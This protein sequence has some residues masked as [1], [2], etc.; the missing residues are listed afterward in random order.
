[1]KKSLAVIMVFIVMLFAFVGCVPS[2]GDSINL[3]NVNEYDET[4]FIQSMAADKTDGITLAENGKAS[5]AIVYPAKADG[6]FLMAI[7]DMQRILSEMI[8]DAVVAESDARLQSGY[9]LCIGNTNR[10]DVNLITFA[11]GINNDGYA[12]KFTENKLFL[13]A[14]NN[15]AAINAIYGF[16]EDE[17]GCVWLDMQNDY[18]PSLPTIILDKKDE[19][20]NPSIVWRS[21]YGYEQMNSIAWKNK[22]KLNGVEYADGREAHSGWGTWCHTFFTFLDPKNYYESNPEY[23]SLQ[24]GKRVANQLCLTNENVYDIVRNNL[25]E[26]IAANPDKK[27]WDVSI[28]DVNKGGCECDE[29]SALDKAE[30][31]GMGSL[32]PFINRLADEFPDVMIS[33]LAYFHN[34]EPPKALKP[35][36]N[37]LIKLCAMP[38]DQ[39]SSYALGATKLAD[40]FKKQVEGWS[41]ISNNLFIWD[42]TTNF[43]YLLMPFPNF[44]VQQANTEFYINNNV[45]GVFHQSSREYGGEMAELRAYIMAK[46]LWDKDID[47]EYNMSKYLQLYYGKTAGGEIASIM[48]RMSDELYKSKK[49]LGLYDVPS[50]HKNGF[51]SSSNVDY[52]FDCYNRAVEA[53]KNNE[54]VLNRLEK[55]KI[56]LLLARMYQSGYDFAAKENAA[57]EYFEL[58]E[59][60]GIKSATEI[61]TDMAEVRNWF[62]SDV[63]M[64]KLEL[65]AI[66]IIPILAASVIALIAC[67]VRVKFKKRNN[68]K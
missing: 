16:L 44:A 50:A 19:I 51:L 5:F 53:S 20:K 34:V 38:G 48:Q 39:A 13:Y 7:K 2:T 30:G 54:I 15:V 12:I 52:Y 47:V 63:R 37:V 58:M 65:S 57:N 18:I 40:N 26:R 49:V 14:D 45:Y 25:A 42:Y 31:S 27:Y 33:T 11:A 23:F 59:K 68:S 29:C 8:G 6:E 10:T 3:T 28:M 56:S 22:L 64:S 1:M 62:E 36:E 46:L 21:V 67:F 32:L 9:E 4:K 35:R 41:K 66:V 61:K 55:Y 24:G 43:S 17:L 60:H